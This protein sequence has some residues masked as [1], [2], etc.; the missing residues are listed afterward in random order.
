VEKANSKNEWRG[1]L[2]GI[3]L[4]FIAMALLAMADWFLAPII[5]EGKIYAGNMVI[6][7]ILIILTFPILGKSLETFGE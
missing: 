7:V 2:K 6:S 4:L 1:A 3:L 5:V